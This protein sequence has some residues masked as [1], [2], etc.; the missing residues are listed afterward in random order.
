MKHIMLYP[1]V[2]M[3][4][5]QSLRLSICEDFRINE[6]SEVNLIFSSSSLEDLPARHH[7]PR[8]SWLLVPSMEALDGMHRLFSRVKDDLH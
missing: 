5:A 8:R 4:H 2:G 7:L 6:E 1:P 3:S